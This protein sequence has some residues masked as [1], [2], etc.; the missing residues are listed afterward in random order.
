[1]GRGFAHP[2]RF[3]K[4]FFCGRKALWRGSAELR[5][6]SLKKLAREFCASFFPHVPSV[7]VK[8]RT[9]C[10]LVLRQLYLYQGYM[11]HFR[12]RCPRFWRPGADM[13]LYS[14]AVHLAFDLLVFMYHTTGSHAA[15]RKKFMW[16]CFVWFFCCLL[17]SLIL[18]FQGGAASIDLRGI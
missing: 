16:F 7:C 4:F 11:P 2:S 10:L 14:N 13:K 17:S 8:N 3:P 1:M 5:T 12:S 18:I 6:H 9:P 15:H